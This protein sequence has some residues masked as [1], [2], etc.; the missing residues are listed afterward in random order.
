MSKKDE[1]IRAAVEA[2]EKCRI[3]AVPSGKDVSPRFVTE[4]LSL[5]RSA[6]EE[7]RRGPPP[8]MSMFATAADYNKAMDEWLGSPIA[9]DTKDKQ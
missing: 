9:A 5:L 3:V 6:M 1:A 8:S 2:L 7:E 4:A